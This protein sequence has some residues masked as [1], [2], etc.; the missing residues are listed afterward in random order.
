VDSSVAATTYCISV[1]VGCTCSISAGLA[2]YNHYL[3]A[4]FLLAADWGGPSQAEANPIRLT[5]AA[6][7]FQLKLRLLLAVIVPAYQ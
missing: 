3:R 4:Y 1:M 5:A 2:V 7:L 6:V